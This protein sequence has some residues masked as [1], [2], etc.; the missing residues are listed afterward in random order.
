M[1]QTQGEEHKLESGTNTGSSGHWLGLDSSSATWWVW[2]VKVGKPTVLQGLCLKG[3]VG[4][5]FYILRGLLQRLI[6]TVMLT[7]WSVH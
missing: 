4:I 6:M 7:V 2:A 1:A 3:E 5:A